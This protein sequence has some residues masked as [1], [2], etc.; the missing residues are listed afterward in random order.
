LPE[1]RVWIDKFPEHGFIDVFRQLYPLRQALH[2]WSYRMKRA[3]QEYRL[4]PG[5]LSGQRTPYDARAGYSH[6]GRDNGFGSLPR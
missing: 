6:F 1:E 4:A 3:R 5:L 2:W